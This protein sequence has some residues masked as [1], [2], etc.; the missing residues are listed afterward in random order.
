MDGKFYVDRNG[1]LRTITWNDI[2]DEEG[3]S[4]AM[5]LLNTL[6]VNVNPWKCHGVTFLDKVLESQWTYFDGLP[7]K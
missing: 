1:S 7:Q 6:Y 5:K 2:D 4:M 3:I